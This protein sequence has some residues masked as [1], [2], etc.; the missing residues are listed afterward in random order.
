[1]RALFHVPVVE[2]KRAPGLGDGIF[3]HDVYL[4]CIIHGIH[5]AGRAC[6]VNN[7]YIVGGIFM[8]VC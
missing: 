3:V 8:Y 7:A 4:F 2:P 5:C 1:M 6:S